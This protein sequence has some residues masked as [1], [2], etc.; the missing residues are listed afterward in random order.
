M[1]LPNF[2]ARLNQPRPY[3]EIVDTLVQSAV[4]YEMARREHERA[5]L[6]VLVARGTARPDASSA[7]HNAQDLEI[8]IAMERRRRDELAAADSA[9]KAAAKIFTEEM[10]SRGNALAAIDLLPGMPQ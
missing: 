8:A 2:N 4:K 1:N 3:T 10:E 9:Y 5:T 6:G 7:W